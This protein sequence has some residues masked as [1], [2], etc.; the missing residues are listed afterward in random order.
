MAE[1][2]VIDGVYVLKE[3]LGKG[4]M[5]SVYLAEVDL[6]R[7]DYTTLYAYTQVE[8]IDSQ[9]PHRPL[10]RCPEGRRQSLRHALTEHA[11]HR[12]LIAPS[13]WKNGI[14]SFVGSAGFNPHAASAHGAPFG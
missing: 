10:P 9:T 6:T 11:G 5:A 2:I 4:G 12:Y 14:S 7:F 8:V 1:T 13:T 3:K